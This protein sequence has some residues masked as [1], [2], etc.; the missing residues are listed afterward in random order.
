MKG[1][2]GGHYVRSSQGPSQCQEEMGHVGAAG[3]GGY[4]GQ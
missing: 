1:F 3:A 2:I 4:G